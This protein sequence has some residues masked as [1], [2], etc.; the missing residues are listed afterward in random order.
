MVPVEW[1]IAAEAAD[2]PVES[3]RVRGGS[4]L[5]SVRQDFFLNPAERLTEQERALMTAM[6]HDLLSAL[7]GEILA[8]DPTQTIEAPVPGEI[9]AAL[10]AANILDRPG[11]VELLLRRADE[12]RIGSAHAGRAAP[13]RL[14]L[15][16]VLVGDANEEIA[17][18]AMALV[19]ARGRRRDAFGQPRLELSDLEPA[20]ASALTYAIA[21]YLAR[22]SG[23]PDASFA[24]AAETVLATRDER[25][26][27]DS[28]LIKLAQVLVR[29]DKSDERLLETV[30]GEGE[31]AILAH[32]LA[33]RAEID[34]YVAWNHVVDAG[35]GRLALLARMAGLS[36]PAAARLLA[37]MGALTGSVAAEDEIAR[38]DALSDAEVGK[39]RD[40]WRLPAHYRVACQA[41]ETADG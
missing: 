14:Q 30:A 7:A 3:A 5:A 13:R 19:I 35:E 12:H 17:A 33:R 23:K 28:A 31:P 32:L 36:R 16:S 21:A 39:A 25:Q 27:L 6:L 38:F 37:D 8:V 15:L 9:A 18:A 29:A 22:T 34:P 1:P 26:S 4:R 41:L 20:D 10:T 24:T 2:R 40:F 11:L